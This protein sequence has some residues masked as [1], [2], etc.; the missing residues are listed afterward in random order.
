M[1]MLAAQAAHREA[2]PNVIDEEDIA[3][4]DK[5]SDTEK[6]DILQRSLNMAASNGDVERVR[7]LVSGHARKHVDVDKPDEE[8]AVPLIYAS[9][10]VRVS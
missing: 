8:G 7:R 2:E 9:C 5:L 6:Q 10:F 1:E 3:L 4:D